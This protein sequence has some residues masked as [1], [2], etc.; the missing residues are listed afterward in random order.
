MEPIVIDFEEDITNF[1]FE[2]QLRKKK[3]NSTAAMTLTVGAGLTKSGTE[4]T[5]KPS[6]TQ[7]DIAGDTY[8]FDLKVTNASG[9]ISRKRFYGI[10]I[11]QDNV[12]R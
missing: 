4:L 5:I 12:T 8:F 9:S 6:V 7:I 3:T 2:L 10:W 1:G 11:I